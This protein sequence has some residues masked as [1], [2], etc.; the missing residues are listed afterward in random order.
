[1][2]YKELSPEKAIERAEFL[3]ARQERCSDDIRKKLVQW[4]VSTSNIDKI[5]KKLVTDGFIN[6]ERFALMF[7]R[8]KSKFNKWGPLKIAYALK[9]KHFSE[10]TIKSALNEIEGTND[11]SQLVEI[12]SKKAKN[13]KAKSPYDLKVKLIRFAVSRG[14]DYGQVNKAVAT[15]IKIDL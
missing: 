9:L 8:D 11:Q 14:F 7:A 6:D 2:I 5:I 4:K 1:M 13:I 15:L 3:C 10:D 12:L